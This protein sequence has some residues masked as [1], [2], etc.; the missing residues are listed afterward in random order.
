VNRR[1]A[2]R[3]TGPDSLRGDVLDFLVLDEYASTAPEPRTEVFRPAMGDKRG[4]A[5][6]IRTPRIKPFFTD[7]HQ[8]A[9]CR[10]DWQVFQFTT[11]EGGNVP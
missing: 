5:L 11:E 4:R 9:S 7:L 6:F 1:L 2:K 10:P 8:A 3:D